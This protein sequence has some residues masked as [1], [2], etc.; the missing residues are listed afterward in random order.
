MKSIE[1]SQR[2]VLKETRQKNHFRKVS[3]KREGDSEEDDGTTNETQSVK[4]E[5]QKYIDKPKL[6]KD[7]DPLLEFWKLK[8]FQYPRLSILA[9]K[10]LT[11]QA[12]NTPSERVFSK[13]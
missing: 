11:V 10:Y 3:L 2:E 9:R 1:A 6:K 4:K 5:L 8:K 7:S 13:I 12:T